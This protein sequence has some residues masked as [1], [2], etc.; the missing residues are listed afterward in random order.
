[1]HV[2]YAPEISRTHCLPQD[3]S[4]HAIRVLR[5]R[6]GSLI[7]VVDGFGG[8]YE[9]SIITEDSSSVTLNI[10]KEQQNFGARNF[11][12]HLALAPTKNIDRF[13]FFLE[14]AVEIG[15]DEITPLSCEHSERFKLRMDRLERIVISA[16]K[17]SY[18]SFKPILNPVTSFSSAIEKAEGINGIAHCA[19]NSRVHIKKFLETNKDTAASRNVNLFIGPEGDFSSE[20]IQA[21][22]NKGFIGI[23]LGSSRLRTETA[24]VVATYAVQFEFGITS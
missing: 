13:E 16:M 20:E 22:E 5:L 4:Y 19:N 21:A 18:K 9:A 10:L 12:L 17:Q 7:H 23:S 1:M 6:K 24:G 14:K 8:F 2:F 15:V 3:E 11:R